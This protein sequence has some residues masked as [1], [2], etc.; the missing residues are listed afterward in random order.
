ML[1]ICTIIIV[2]LKK[3]T[4]LKNILR[5]SIHIYFDIMWVLKAFDVEFVTFSAT[6]K[7]VS[8]IR[9]VQYQ[10]S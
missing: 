3:G 7:S 10:S 5:N 6:D 1:S 8:H 2:E 4:C 9:V